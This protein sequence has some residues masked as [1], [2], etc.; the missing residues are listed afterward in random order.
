[1]PNPQPKLRPEP[2]PQAML[3][4][5]EIITLRQVTEYLN[6]NSRWRSG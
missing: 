3:E 6:R 5:R 2:E 1:L 4:D